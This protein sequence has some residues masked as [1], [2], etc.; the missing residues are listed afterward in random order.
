LYGKNKLPIDEIKK[1]ALFIARKL[2]FAQNY[3]GMKLPIYIVVT[4]SDIVPGFQSFCSEIPVRNR[5]NMLG[6]SSP[7]SSNTIFTSR[8]LDNAFASLEDELNE[9]RMEIFSESSVTTMRDGVFVFPSELLTIKESLKCYIET[10]FKS[11]SAEE[12]FYF[13]GFYFT[14]DSKMVPLL[15]F[16]QSNR[17]EE[18]MAIMG[19]P[20]ADIN[21]AGSMTATILD[22]QFSA[23]KIFFFED[24]L[25]KKVFMED[26]IAV[27]M[28]SKIHQTNKSIFIAKISTAAFVVIGSYGLF[29][30]KDK[31]KQS[32]DALFPALF[33]ISSLIK[34][35]SDLT[36]KNLNNNGNEILAECTNQL[37]SMMH[38]INY[39]RFSSVFVPA[40]WCGSID[41]SLRETLRASYQK[42][43]IRTI[44]MNLLLRARMFLNMKPTSRSS[45][46]SEILNPRNSKEYAA[47]K[48]YV[49]GL[50]ELEKNIKRFDSLRT[51]GDPNDLNDLIDY[52]FH[53]C[54]SR[55]FLDS[56]QQFRQVLMNTPFPSINLT[57]Y[58]QT[59]YNVLIDLFQAYLDTI[60][61]S[62]SENSIVSMLSTFIE[63]LTHQ[64][65]KK[66]PDLSKMR[67]FAKDL[68]MV[69]DELGEDGKTWLDNDIFIPDK[70][71]DE[72]LDGVE[73]LFGK[74]TAQKLLDVTAVN[75]GYLKSKISEFNNMLSGGADVVESTK[76]SRK[77]S[78]GIYLM[79]RCLTALFSENFMEIPGDYRLV[80]EIPEGKMFFWDDELVQKAYEIGQRFVKFSLTTIKDF[81]RFMQEGILLAAKANMIAVIDSTI[82]K[83][84][85]IVDSPSA[86]TSEITSEEILQK[87]V[88]EL[89]GVAPR[90]VSLLKILRDD[91]LGFVFGNLR[92][93]LNKVAFSLLRHID[94]LL[95]KQQPYRPQ[96]LTF[97]SWNGEQGAGLLAFSASDSEELA[98][99]IQLQRSVIERL[100][101]DFA[102]IIVDFLNLAV[103][104]DQNHG[105]LKLL[106]KWTRIVENVRGFRKRN[107]ASSMTVVERF[108]K[109][110]LNGYTIDNITSKISSDEIKAGSGDYF[111]NIVKEIKR[112][113]MSRAEILLR[114]RNIER[115]NALRDYYMKHLYGRFPFT[116]YDKAQRTANDA[117][118]DAV[119]EFF[120][121][122]DEFGGEPEIILDQIYQ[123]GKDAQKLYEF[124]KRIHEIR[125]FFGDSLG[126]NQRE[127]VKVGLEIDFAINKREETNT[128]YLVTRVFRLN[129]DKKVEPFTE[130]KIV[131]WYLGDIIGIYLRWAQGDDQ[132]PYPVS[133]PNDPD[134]ILDETGVTVQC[135]GNWSV[136]RFLQKYR[137]DV[138][139]PDKTSSNQIVLVFKIPLSDGKISKIYV[140]I[141]AFVPKKPGDPTAL[142]VKIPEKPP[143]AMP[144]VPIAVVA[145][146]NEPVLTSRSWEMSY[147]KPDIIHTVQKEVEEKN[148]EN[149]PRRPEHQQPNSSTSFKKISNQSNEP[150]KKK[151]AESEQI[152]QILESND[153]QQKEESSLV[154]TSEELIQ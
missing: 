39:A 133:D 123:L 104:Y 142:L 59:A 73:V 18:T 77:L 4:K 140:G 88:A 65:L 74:D 38:Q 12:K 57:S 36:F 96:D 17:D 44:Y 113:I 106:T 86:M 20:D 124:L 147:E 89:K 28:L 115:Y 56:Y 47:V 24:L 23:K 107:P 68:E 90:F 26:G 6:W 145:V 85:S 50:I 3:L 81:P 101:L 141:K 154:E 146:T 42:V 108:I 130:D 150:E 139:S 136:F 110:I 112:G 93:V 95:D 153:E 69:C 83:A 2:N 48:E 114:K 126:F 5:A 54:L 25:L 51:S 84:Q 87:Q 129:T 78:S 122:Y 21:E 60:F 43:V 66:V 99:Y 116:N 105:E 19:T 67:N 22:D 132:A 103:I 97:R 82:A 27:P 131:I 151:D 53:G 92:G 109:G 121:M 9:I 102:G 117:D 100:A 80:T 35:A 31:L 143:E 137:A 152:K 29:S 58:R 63:N 16:D 134:V 98:L 118:L 30:A 76:E 149:A 46:I 64:Q 52:T 32:R 71:F 11:S 1:R 40:S 70:E 79:N 15:Q 8:I 41:S 94:S 14:G 55:E 125:L 119:R 111:L 91:K 10:I 7:F 135:V 61:T 75:F 148:K 72:F 144:E 120:K 37:L 62:K 34:S 33:K 13:R 49:F 138:V 128:D 127:G 45:N